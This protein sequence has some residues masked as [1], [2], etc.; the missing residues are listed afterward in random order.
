MSAAADPPPGAPAAPA[1][2][3]PPGVAAFDFDGTLIRGDSFMPFLVKAV[4]PARFGRIV[5]GS[6]ASTARAYQA[7]R[8]DASKAVLVRRLLTG[9]PAE[10]LADL[11][12]RYGAQLAQRIRSSM[13]ERVTWHRD[14]GHRLVIVSASL[15]V[16]LAPT[17]AA[18]GFDQVL[19]TR[20]EVDGGGLLT[21]RLDGPNVR[22]PEK[23]ARLR[24]WLAEALPDTAYQLWAYGDSAGD[25]DLL[26]MAD[27]PVR[28]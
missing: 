11:G 28:V 21:G 9:Y 20:L 6:S 18:L 12:R 8:R 19:A 16:Y 25:R 1:P 15:E 22:G 10:R 24:A 17:G 26:A 23:S 14:Q 27:H 3:V 13:A 2:Q 7:G 4:G 5:I